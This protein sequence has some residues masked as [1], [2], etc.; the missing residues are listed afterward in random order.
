M[1]QLILIT[2]LT[3]S[4]RS[5]ANNQC[6]VTEFTAINESL[7]HMLNITQFTN[8]DVCAGVPNNESS[9]LSSQNKE[10]YCQSTSHD[11]MQRLCLLKG[12]LGHSNA[13][14][15]FGLST[16]VC[17]WNSQFHRKVTYLTYCDPKKPSHYSDEETANII[18]SIG[19]FKVTAINGY[20]SFHSFIT[21]PKYPNRKNILQKY[22]QTQMGKS[23][24]TFEWING[25]RNRSNKKPRSE[26]LIQKQVEEIEH[27]MSTVKPLK[28]FD[29]F[30]VYGVMQIPGV[31]AHSM[32]IYELNKI[33]DAQGR[34][35]YKMKTHDPSYQDD[36]R[37]LGVESFNFDV[38]S[39]R[40]YNDQNFQKLQNLRK[41]HQSPRFYSRSYSGWIRDETPESMNAPDAIGAEEW[42]IWTYKENDKEKI[43]KAFKEACGRDLF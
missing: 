37:F 30:P 18:K 9:S 20:D 3:L 24:V 34:V 10:A 5:T 32:L 14:G 26:E 13:G 1:K 4:F 17:W 6:P 41:N 12:K 21:D 23:T 11:L 7:N 22:L 39:G 29:S 27:M 40:W 35:Y 2:L 33:T 16:G 28:R 42:S 19:K 15:I 8:T 31:A 38:E 43:A 36:N 25:L